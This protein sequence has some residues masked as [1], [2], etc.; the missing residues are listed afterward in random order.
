[1]SKSYPLAYV[2][3]LA[4]AALMYALGDFVALFTILASF[5]SPIMLLYFAVDWFV[6][7][8]VA[9]ACGYGA[10]RSAPRAWLLGYPLVALVT[11]VTPVASTKHQVLAVPVPWLAAYRVAKDEVLAAMPERLAWVSLVFLGAMLAGAVHRWIADRRAGAEGEMR[12]GAVTAVL[13]A[14]PLV[15]A[16]AIAGA[17]R[18]HEEGVWGAN[19]RAPVAANFLPVVSAYAERTGQLGAVCTALAPDSGPDVR[20]GAPGIAHSD[21]PGLGVAT[22]PVR[23][24]EPNRQA[25]RD[26]ALL[27]YDVLARAGYFTASETHV[28]NAVG[29]VV[30]A[31]RY[32][33]TLAGWEASENGCFALGRPEVLEIKSFARIEP[34]PREARVYEVVYT[35]GI[36]EAADWLGSED[37]KAGFGA[38]LKPP[39][40][41]EARLRLVKGRSGWL[42]EPLVSGETGLDKAKLELTFDQLL[43]PV[44]LKLVPQLAARAKLQSNAPSACLLIPSRPGEHA[45]QIEAGVAGPYSATFAEEAGI[46]DQ[47]RLR[48]MWK[49]RLDHLAKEGVFRK[50]ILVGATR[51]V[52]EPQYLSFID[53]QRPGCLRLGQ[54][55]TE[56]LKARVDAVGA[57]D[58]RLARVKGI[59]RI[60][61]D[62]WSRKIDLSP[63]PEAAAFVHS[64]VPVSALLEL[65][66]G[67][68]K[69]VSGG[70][71]MPIAIAPPAEP[72]PQVAARRPPSG[73]PATP[74]ASAGVHV[75][76]V[77]QSAGR[78]GPID[79]R[80]G[81]RGRP[82]TLVLSAYEPV[83]WRIATEP[84]VV[85]SRVFVLG[86]NPAK[87]Q[88]VE[89]GKLA[90]HGGTYLPVS[91]RHGSGPD[92]AAIA[93]TVARIAGKPPDSLQAYYEVESF[94]LGGSG[95]SGAVRPSAAAPKTPLTIRIPAGATKIP[96][97]AREVIIEPT[98]R[99]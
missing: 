45:A 68:W 79:V 39:S 73:T 72:A 70:G 5:G 91:G 59:A 86:Y 60:D 54:T 57:Q 62:A 49:R 23:A 11:F 98:E 8:L 92:T 77:Y 18:T 78:H 42:P 95:G 97:P 75:L 64:G 7:P 40:P 80:V 6:P 99:R 44:D 84:G 74:A 9:F 52:L 34:E 87:V 17:W 96:L 12:S 31:R 50:E 66:D 69:M 83:T 29:E 30:P 26:R 36:R 27:R 20:R 33:M 37:A 55:R 13:I 56:Y 24:A 4:L 58:K 46:D 93:Q 25:E 51:F 94:S 35:H 28:V 19:P 63:L 89:L 15:A 16:A 67:K 85:I 43:P 82:V 53:K 88:G 48:A 21:I 14:L 10:R 61:S 47:A 41:K 65:A 3:T 71:Y 90:F 38:G 32:V 22:L 1:M 2:I 76:A 81:L